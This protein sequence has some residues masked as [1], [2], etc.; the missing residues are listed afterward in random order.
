[1]PGLGSPAGN[2]LLTQNEWFSR[3]TAGE[4]KVRSSQELAGRSGARPASHF[5]NIFNANMQII[6][7]ILKL[8]IN[9]FQNKT[10]P[11]RGRVEVAWPAT[12]LLAVR[13]RASRVGGAAGLA[14]VFISRMKKILSAAPVAPTAPAGG[15]DDGLLFQLQSDQPIRR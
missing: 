7:L 8:T 11:A 9:F 14:L 3:P 1:M 13:C 15:P 2:S 4:L 5:P 12:A 6:L 10:I